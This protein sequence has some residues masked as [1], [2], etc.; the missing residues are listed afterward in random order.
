M[1]KARMLL[2]CGLAVALGACSA[3]TMWKEKPANSWSSATGAE[4]FERLMWR[5]VKEQHWAE[6]ESHLA[7]T[8]VSLYPGGTRDRAATMDYLKSLAL[9]DYT[10]GEFNTT[11]NGADMVV[12]YTARVSGTY[13]GQ[14]LSSEPIRMMT[15]WQQ[16]TK[17]WIAIAH[18]EAHAT[19]PH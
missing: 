7:P 4:H 9:S 18:S 1:T 13:K 11:T 17:S 2:L 6:V 19:G 15:V 12:T 8:F 3:C 5:D 10:L 16:V 14:P